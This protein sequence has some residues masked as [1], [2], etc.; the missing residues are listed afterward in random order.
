M[1]LQRLAI[2]QQNASAAQTRATAYMGNYL[3]MAYN[4]GL[5]G[6]TLAGAPVISDNA[7][8]QSVVGS[9]NAPTAIA[10]QANAAQFNDVYGATDNMENSAKALVA[11]KGKGALN[12]AHV[13]AALA[14][15]ANDFTSM[16]A[17]YVRQQRAYSGAAE[18]CHR[19]QGIQGKPAGSAQV[20]WRQRF[21]FPS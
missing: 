12:D 20:R 9:R 8:G 1:A 7:G 5:H 4:T 19:D 11:K 17:R 2:A 10:N 18:L 21:G 16:G 15:P 3:Q 13:A 6:E 14:D